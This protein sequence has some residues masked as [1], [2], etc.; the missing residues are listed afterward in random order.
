MT[1]QGESKTGQRPGDGLKASG[2]ILVLLAVVLGGIGLA[3]GAGLVPLAVLL[4]VLGAGL[5]IL[6]YR[7]R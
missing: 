3:N 2:V 4:G 6:G 5:L 7:R 1:S